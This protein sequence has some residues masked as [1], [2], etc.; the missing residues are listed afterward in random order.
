MGD[1]NFEFAI[2]E[3]NGRLT[4]VLRGDLDAYTGPRFTEWLRKTVAAGRGDV[5]MDMSDVTFVDS[6][7]IAIL[8]ATAKQLQTRDSKLVVQSP[9]RMVAKVLEMTGVT[10]LVK[11]ERRSRS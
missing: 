1:T 9:P 6:S 5:V 2:R 3:N 10:K 4:L 7:G 11:I 8:V